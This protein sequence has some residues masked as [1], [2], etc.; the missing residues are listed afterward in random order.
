MGPVCKE[1]EREDIRGTLTQV[2]GEPPLDIKPA[3]HTLSLCR[4]LHHRKTEI[5]CSC[6]SWWHSKKNCRGESGKIFKFSLFLWGRQIKRKHENWELESQFNSKEDFIAL[7]EDPGSAPSTSWQLAA[8]SSWRIIP[9]SW[10]LRHCV[11]AHT[12]TETQRQRANTDRQIET[13][14]Q[15]IKIKKKSEWA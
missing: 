5:T 11:H 10:L 1:Q 6:W 7:S 8:F 12:H 9:Y 14:T 2:E 3:A 15:T 13:H 4:T